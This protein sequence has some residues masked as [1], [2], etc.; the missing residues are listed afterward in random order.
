MDRWRG[1]AEIVAIADCGTFVGAASK[2]GVSTSHISRAIADLEAKLGTRL[3]ERTTRSVRLTD[4]GRTLV[5][6][7]RRILADCDEA[8]QLVSHQADMQGELRITC[9]IALGEAFVVPIVRQYLL[10]NPS[11]SVTLELTNRVIDLV[12]E[13][14]DVGIRT[15]HP[16]DSRLSAMQIATRSMETC[17]SPAYLQRA[18]VP[19]RPADLDRHQCLVG[20]NPVWHFKEMG[21]RIA[22]VP[23]G[24]WRC[25]SG[26]ALVDAALADMGICQLPAY[27][28]Q[29][30][31]RAGRLERV[32][33]RFNDDAEII[34]AAYPQRRYLIPKVR[35]IVDMLS[36][37]LPGMVP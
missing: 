20:T 22:F 36:D 18:G 27:Y 12:G 30:H 23:K 2:L 25:N 26:T 33:A 13:S 11:I 1:L 16:N 35:R 21:K 15:G 3:V 34:W 37:N 10:D 5:E 19:E 32:L 4:S 28:V 24:R 8:L 31:V 9:S 29:D 6:Q 7:S 14:F 17:A